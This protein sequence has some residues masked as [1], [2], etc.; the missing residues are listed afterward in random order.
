MNSHLHFPY[1]HGAMVREDDQQRDSGEE[2]ASCDH[3][4]V[5]SLSPETNINDVEHPKVDEHVRT[6]HEKSARKQMCENAGGCTVRG[7]SRAL[8]RSLILYL[9]VPGSN[10]P[11]RGIAAS[12]AQ[13]RFLSGSTWCC[14]TPRSLNLSR[15]EGYTTDYTANAWL[16]IFLPIR[17]L[18]Y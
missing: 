4:H 5:W 3:R 9:A 6:S 15:W 7:V 16:D 13:W 17:F 14:F 10:C 2:L 18:L 1:F 12:E 8:N 11:L